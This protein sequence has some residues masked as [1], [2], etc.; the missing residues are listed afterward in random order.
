MYLSNFG[1][2]LA[3][4]TDSTAPPTR[5][6]GTGIFPLYCQPDPAEP[7]GQTERSDMRKSKEIKRKRREGASKY[8]KGERVEA[9]KLWTEAAAE[10]K[11]RRTPK[12]PAAGGEAAA[13]T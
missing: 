8:R 7:D 12:K 13:A 3:S 1:T 2:I 5:P 10:Y 9:Y 4:D 11:A 6:V